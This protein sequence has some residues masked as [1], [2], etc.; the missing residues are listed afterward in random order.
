[1]LMSAL[2]YALGANVDPTVSAILII[3]F[4]MMPNVAFVAIRSKGHPWHRVMRTLFFVSIVYLT[5]EV[6]HHY[7]IL[8]GPYTSGVGREFAFCVPYLVLIPVG[9][10]AGACLAMSVT[11]LILSKKKGA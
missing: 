2:G 8:V 9:I 7:N 11:S 3:F 4:M 5:T 10:L 6:A 1:M